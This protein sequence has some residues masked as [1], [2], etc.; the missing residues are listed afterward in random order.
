[1]ENTLNQEHTITAVLGITDMA[2]A[3]ATQEEQILAEEDND[4]A[5]DVQ[6]N[7]TEGVENIE[8]LQ[9]QLLNQVA[10]EDHEIQMLQEANDKNT[11]T[12]SKTTTDSTVEYNTVTDSTTATD[13]TTE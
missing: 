4:G 1:L 8:E 6:V 9:Q 5:M 12:D 2:K 11:A 13:S 7:E 3:M 10:D